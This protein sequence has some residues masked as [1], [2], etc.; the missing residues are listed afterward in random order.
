[1]AVLKSSADILQ[2]DI[3]KQ[4]HPIVKS[5]IQSIL[6]FMEKDGKIHR[7]KSGRTYIIRYNQAT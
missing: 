4:F 6:Y 3:Y 7:E 1:M 2:T 5:D